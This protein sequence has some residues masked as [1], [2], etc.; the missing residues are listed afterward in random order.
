MGQ[1]TERIESEI[2]AER[3]RLR[4]NL[5][6]LGDRVRSATSWRRQFHS[7]PLLGLGVAFTGGVLLAGLL[8][9]AAKTRP[10]AQRATRS[11]RGHLTNVWETVQDA[12]LGIVASRVTGMLVDLVPGS[13]EPSARTSQSDAEPE[14]RNGDGVQG[15]G[16]YAAKRREGTVDPQ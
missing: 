7:N 8:R 5:D 1:R 13:R 9:P 6:E 15:E 10:Y 3:G 12:L 11:D 14:Y 16:N 2:E 4:A